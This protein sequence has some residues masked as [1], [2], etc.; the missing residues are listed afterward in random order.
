MEALWLALRAF[1]P[2]LSHSG[3]S[4]LERSFSRGCRRERE[5]YKDTHTH[6]AFPQCPCLSS[7]EQAYRKK[8][9]AHNLCALS[10]FPP[11]FSSQRTAK[12]HDSTQLT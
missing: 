11:G 8:S 2:N 12:R 4:N 10:G 6:T 7:R 3:S 1:K 9:L 5:Q